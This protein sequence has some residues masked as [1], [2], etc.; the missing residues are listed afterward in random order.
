M[1]SSLREM[2]QLHPRRIA[3]LAPVLSG[4]LRE[5][6]VEVDEEAVIRGLLSGKGETIEGLQRLTE[7]LGSYAVLAQIG[8]SRVDYRLLTVLDAAVITLSEIGG[9]DGI[10]RSMKDEERAAM[11]LILGNALYEGGFP[12][13]ASK[14]YGEA[15]EIRRELAARDGRFLPDLAGTLNNLGAALARKGRLDEAIE[16]LEEALEYYR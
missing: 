15:L 13:S 6:G 7:E 3:I 5:R 10:F 1:L 8:G 2:G 11:L 14:V 4:Y 12:D 9:I 16:R